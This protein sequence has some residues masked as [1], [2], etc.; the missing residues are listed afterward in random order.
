MLGEIAERHIHNDNVYA[1]AVKH[2]RDQTILVRLALLPISYREME[3][4]INQREGLTAHCLQVL[5]LD[6]LNDGAL[7]EVAMRGDS[8]IKG[9]THRDPSLP[10]IATMAVS[11]ISKPKNLH[12]LVMKT[13]RA[14]IAMEAVSRLDDQAILQEIATDHA[15]RDVRAA[16]IYRI[17][18]QKFLKKAATSDPDGWVRRTAAE[19][20]DDVDF[21]NRYAK[22][23]GMFFRNI[24]D[25]AVLEFLAAEA[26]NYA[27]RESAKKAIKALDADAAVRLAMAGDF[28]KIRLLPEKEQWE[29]AE[30]M[31]QKGASA[32][33]NTLAM[34]KGKYSGQLTDQDVLM[35]VFEN[36]SVLDS[37][38]AAKKLQQLG[39]P[40][41]MQVFLQNN[42]T[43]NV[44]GHRLIIISRGGEHEWNYTQMCIFCEKTGGAYF[45]SEN[46]PRYFGFNFHDAYCSGNGNSGVPYP[47]R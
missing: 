8:S 28:T 34:E 35:A 22:E 23:Y 40:E 33:L 46:D 37:W 7:L 27:D 41:P 19:R 26:A 31:A 2:I 10:G 16:A 13:D 21:I 1:A 12:R 4:Y 42:Q 5:A 39:Y 43:E 38:K 24:S 32:W 44:K 30:Y 47:L 15:D 3:R 29:K 20:I 6:K 45:T 18:D 11:R 17:N 14:S 25:R 9:E 36:G